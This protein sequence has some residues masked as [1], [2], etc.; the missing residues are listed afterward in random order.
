M[1][2]KE[3]I[4]VY[5]RVRPP[6]SDDLNYSTAVHASSSTTI[7]LSDKKHDVTCEYENVF[8]ETATQKE[9]K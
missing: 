4:H 9:N 1:S 7:N 6:I 2:S 5:V 8:P 3:G